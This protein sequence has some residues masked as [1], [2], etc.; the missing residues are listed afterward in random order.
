MD[1]SWLVGRFVTDV[2]FQE[3]ELWF[4]CFGEKGNIGAECL[5]RIIDRGR[6]VLCSKDHGQKFGLPSPINAAAKGAELL[7][8]RTVKAFRVREVTTDITIEFSGDLLLEIIP[9]SSGYESWQVNE[10]SGVGYF[11][12]LFFV[13]GEGTIVKSSAQSGS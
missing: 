13:E 2:S 9:D 7:A 10:P 3:P 12:P 8:G 5:W 6:I 1:L 4:F 11:G